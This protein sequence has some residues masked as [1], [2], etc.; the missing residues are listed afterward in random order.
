MDNKDRTAI[1]EFITLLSDFEWHDLYD[2]H[3]KYNLSPPVIFDAFSFPSQ[4]GLILREGR[5]IKLS[6]S[7]TAE[8]FSLL[9][10]L[11]KTKRPEELKEF[12]PSRL[13]MAHRHV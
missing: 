6:S 7:L 4:N 1:R 12:S 11:C 2:L 10:R 9:N 8:H 13:T 3:A 5:S